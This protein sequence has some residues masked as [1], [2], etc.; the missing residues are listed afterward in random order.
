MAVM[1]M[2]CNWLPAWQGDHCAGRQLGELDRR[3]LRACHGS[4]DPAATISLLK[5]MHGNSNNNN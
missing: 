2:P 3:A 4:T 1:T 5:G